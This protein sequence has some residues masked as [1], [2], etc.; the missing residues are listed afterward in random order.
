MLVV[1]HEPGDERAALYNE[2]SDPAHQ[3]DRVEEEPLEV[4]DLRATLD[5]A[6]AVLAKAR[7]AGSDREIDPETAQRLRGLGYVGGK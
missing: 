3:H 5:E 7:L 6:F 2:V 1:A 4:R